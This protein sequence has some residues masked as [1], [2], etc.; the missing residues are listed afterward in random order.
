MQLDL[1]E[2]PQNNQFSTE[3]WTFFFGIFFFYFSNVIW[4]LSLQMWHQNHMKN[5]KLHLLDKNINQF[6]LLWTETDKNDET[7]SLKDS[8]NM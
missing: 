7:L 4:S 3:I 2:V 8:T 1:R 6:P 5:M